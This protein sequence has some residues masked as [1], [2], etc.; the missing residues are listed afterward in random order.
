MSENKNARIYID[1]VEITPYVMDFRLDAVNGIPAVELE[2]F[3]FL[4]ITQGISI[5]IPFRRRS[6]KQV[7][8]VIRRDENWMSEKEL[9]RKAA[10]RRRNANGN[11]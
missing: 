11:N 1:D 5:T 3:K 9:R 8:R 7:K 6:W 10:Y 2:E 4:P